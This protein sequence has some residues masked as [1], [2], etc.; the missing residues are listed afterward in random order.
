MIFASEAYPYLFFYFSLSSVFSFSI[1]SPLGPFLVSVELFD[2][3]GSG[4]RVF[5]LTYFL[6]VLPFFGLFLGLGSGS[7]IF[8]GPTNVDYQ[9][10]FWK[11]NPISLYLIWSHL[12]PFLRFLSSSL[13]FWS[14]NDI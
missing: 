13:L 7:K 4:S 2:R 5:F 8:L 10:W 6:A 1:F 14:E 9:F 11:Y 3:F 12:E